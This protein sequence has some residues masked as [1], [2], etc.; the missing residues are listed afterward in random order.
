MPRFLREPGVFLGT[1]FNVNLGVIWTGAIV[2]VVVGAT[3]VVVVLTIAVVGA[4][5]V[6]VVFT[7]AVVFV[8]TDEEAVET[9]QR[10]A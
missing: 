10:P 9:W 3:V 8:A 4:T 5:V 6:V 7:I 2:V 1:G